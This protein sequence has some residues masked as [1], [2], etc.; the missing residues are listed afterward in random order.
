MIIAPGPDRLKTVQPGTFNTSL[1]NI[2]YIPTK[3]GE[4]I[5]F[6]F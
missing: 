1:E 5:L 3:I 6:Q 2:F 4:E